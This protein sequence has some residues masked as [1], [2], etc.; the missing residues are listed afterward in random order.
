MAY[1]RNR[2]RGQIFL[3]HRVGLFRPVPSVAKRTI[4]SQMNHSDLTRSILIGQSAAISRLRE[5]IRLIAGRRVTVLISG[6]SGTGKEVVARAIHSAGNRAQRPMVAV[7]CTALPSNLL[8]SELFGHVKGAFTGADRL[9]IGRFEQAHRGTIFLDEVGDLPLESQGKLLRVLQEQQFERLG[10]SETLSVDVRVVAATNVRLEDA[11]R[12]RKF[13]EDLYYRLNVIPVQLIPLRDRR[14]DIP[15]LIEHFLNKFQEEER[16]APKSLSA[17]AL[18][19]LAGQAWP[20]NVRQLEHTIQRAFAMSGD[21]TTIGLADLHFGCTGIADAEAEEE[22]YQDGSYVQVH[23]NGIDFDKVIGNLERSLVH[24]ALRL[25]GGN[26]AKAAD[27][28]R[29]KR[30]TLLAKIKTFEQRQMPV[31]IAFPIRSAGINSGVG[32]AEAACA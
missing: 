14:E 29:M 23:Q 11:V 31:P 22:P 13:R 24:Q 8:E 26:K 9:R 12:E 27:L 5:I 28:L 2:F 20:G 17:E 4:W 25:S 32:Q 16:C 21:R 1:R 6:E 30:T 18:R 15:L 7:N 10:S 19:Y 3:E